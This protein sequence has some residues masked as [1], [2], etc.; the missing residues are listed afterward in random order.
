GSSARAR[1]AAPASVASSALATGQARPSNASWAA[2][3]TARG[4]APVG[5]PKTG[6]W[7]D[8]VV[9]FRREDLGRRSDGGLLGGDGPGPQIGDGVL[10]TLGVAEERAAGHG[11]VGAGA[12]R[13]GHGGRAD[14][15]VDLE[16]DVEAAAVDQGPGLG[17][18]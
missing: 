12:G 1:R 6:P 7:F 11:G 14:A 8:R 4:P 17:H 13:P 5:P 3:S 10:E 15:P 18:R 2:L 16:L 9:G